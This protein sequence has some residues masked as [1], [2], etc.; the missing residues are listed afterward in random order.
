MEISFPLAWQPPQWRYKPGTYLSDLI[1]HEG[2]GSLHSYL[3]SKGWITAL[4]SGPQALARG[5][6]MFRVTV[7]MT[8][9]GFSESSI[10]SLSKLN[11]D[12]SV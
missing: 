12:V 6:A 10:A 9:D 11:V 4:V 5:F 2:P 1:G 7:H 3:K 8:E